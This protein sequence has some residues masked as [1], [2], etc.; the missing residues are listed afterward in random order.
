MSAGLDFASI[1]RSSALESIPLV[2]GQFHNPTTM[3]RLAGYPV[4]RSPEQ[5]RLHPALEELGWTGVIDEF[6]DAAPRHEHAVPE[7][8]LITVSGTILAGFGHWRSSVLDGRQEINCIEY[9]LS[10]DD[11][12]QFMLAYDQRGCKW[13]AF[14]RIRLALKLEAHFQQRALD[15]MRA[16]GK[17]KGSA[18]LPEAQHID[19]RQEVAH[20]AGVGSRN[21]SNVKVILERAHPRLIDALAHGR[22]SIYRALQWSTL[23][24]SKQLDEFTRYTWESARNKVIRQAIAQ[25]KADKIKLDLITL[26][27]ALRRQ[28]MRQ[29]GSVVLRVSRP[30][31][32]LVLIGEDLLTDLHSQ[33]GPAP[34]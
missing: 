24:K 33:R 3:S 21:V 25:P 22:L 20:T 15:N 11:S 4:V 7:P 28:E 1:R 19:V 14:T 27:D 34:L 10:D 17:Y 29:A 5:L 26:L 13:N 32:T 30:R 12:L 16:G 9:A 31:R 23:P 2:A 6:N 18:N 8:I